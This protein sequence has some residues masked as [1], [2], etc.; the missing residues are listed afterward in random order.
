M[1]GL[2][3]VIGTLVGFWLLF[4]CWPLESCW[5]KFKE[6]IV[7]NEKLIAATTAAFTIVLAIATGFLA[8]ATI[9]LV[10]D[11]RETAERQLRAY[12]YA[13]PFRA[14]NI[15]ASGN[16][17]QV[18]TTIGSKGSTFATRVERWVGVNLLSGA[19][20]EKFEDLGTLKR[21]EGV[22]V[23]APG[24]D[25]FVIRNFRKLS[26]E[27]LRKLMTPDGELRLYAFGKIT[28]RDAFGEGH[29]TTFCHVYFGPERLPFNGGFAYESWQ[30]KF[31]DLHNDAN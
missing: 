26:V 25:G 16:V 28:Y 23:L 20:P 4:A 5:S 31:C 3:W 1:A 27:E 9:N 17:A 6:K 21:E 7:S 10:W 2:F 29:Q 14:F 19:V 13:A 15:D 18:Y 24:A 22:M 11:G 30:A 12:V 8:W